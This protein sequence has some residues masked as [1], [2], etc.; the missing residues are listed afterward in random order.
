MKKYFTILLCFAV[1]FCS[2]Q[3]NIWDFETAE[4]STEFQHFGGTLEGVVTSAIANPDASGANTSAMVIQIAK[5]DDAPTWGGAFSTMPPVG[6]IDATNGGQVCMDVWMD[7]IGNISL[8]LET[9]DPNDPVNYRQEVVNTT[10]NEWENICFDLDL[11]SLDGAMGP[12]TGNMY[13]NIVMFVDFGVAG[14][15]TQVDAYFDNFTIPAGGGGGGDVT[16]TT[17]IDYE[18]LPGDFQYFGSGLDGTLANTI[19]NPNPT[20]INTSA[21]V[22][23]YVKAGDAMTWAGA[24]LANGLSTPIDG[25]LTSEICLK[26]HS[27]HPGN[28]TLKLEMADN[29]DP[30]NWI[31]TQPLV[32]NNEWEEVCFDL[33]Q[34]SIEG[35]MVS[36]VGFAYTTMV[37]FPDFGIAGAG[38]DINF[39]FDDFVVKTSNVVNDYD[40]TFS[41]DMNEYTGAFTQVYVS[42]TFNNWSGDGNPLSDVDNDGVWE[43]TVNVTQG[44]H[45]YKFTLDNWTEQE[46][47]PVTAECTISTD[48]GSGNIFI[49]R[50]MSVAADA[51]EGTYCYNSC[52]ACG[53]GLTITW[54]VNDALID[55]VSPEGLFVAGGAAFGHGDFPLNDDDG[56][57]IW[58]LTIER[59]AGFTSDYT[60]ING[61]CL[62]DWSCKENIAG[63]ACAVEPFNDRNLPALTENVVINTCYGECSTDGSCGVVEMYDVTFNVDMSNETV[64]DGVW[65][66]GNSINNWTAMTTELLDP[67]GDNTYTVTVQLPEGAHEYKFLNGADAEIIDSQEPCTITDPSGQFTNRLLLLAPADTIVNLVSFGSCE[68]MVNNENVFVD[69]NLVNIYP[70]ITNQA[71][72]IDFN[73]VAPKQEIS[74][75]DIA[76]KV[77]FETEFNNVATK[78]IEVTDFPKGLHFVNVKVGQKTTTKKLLVQ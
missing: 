41:V 50:S 17:I 66:F 45:E 8:K 31:T 40:I 34:P 24:F 74:I 37:I 11:N 64:T 75:V 38:A 32:G 63:Q 53:E 22:L 7:H 33:T 56:D 23:E 51:T 55:A 5:A 4:T 1:T 21:N 76:G 18:T 14:T 54:M 13:N 72:T 6:G 43:G 68:L 46:Q 3:T 44:I 2:A 78:Q 26:A 12:G 67:E 10:M 73:E 59:A 65:I 19:A 30:N 29:Q 15:G 47:F 52:Y 20:G 16:C 39:Y 60:F 48:D 77:I 62:P 28:M 57:G 9:A 69:N 70:T 61:I 49:N 36:A 25:T 71:V 27:D 42:G 58:T 35:N